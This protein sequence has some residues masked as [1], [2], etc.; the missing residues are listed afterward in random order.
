MH[1]SSAGLLQDVSNGCERTG[2]EAELDNANEA[3]SVEFGSGWPDHV[4]LEAE[5]GAS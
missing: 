1:R 4:G 3:G 5:L 2:V